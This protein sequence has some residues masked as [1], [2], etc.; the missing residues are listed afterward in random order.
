[1]SSS[2]KEQGTAAFHAEKWEEAIN[3]YTEALKAGSLSEEEA[4]ALYSNRAAARIHLYRYDLALLD[5]AQACKLRPTWSRAFAR[6]AEAYSHLHRDDLALL[7][8]QE[9]ISLAEDPS[10]R[11]RYESAA[12]LVRQRIET[13]ANKT[14]ALISEV[15][16]NDFC[17]RYNELL[18]KEDPRVGSGEL[19]SAEAAVYAYEMIEKAMLELDDQ[20]LM[21]EDGTVEA[22]SPSPILDIADGIL[23]D[24]R[25]FHIPPGKDEKCPLAQKLT[26]QLECDLRVLNLNDYIKR[27]ATPDELLDDFH[28]MVQKEDNWELARLSLSTLIRGSFVSG[29]LAEAQGDTYLA[30][31]KYLYALGIVEAGRERWVDVSDDDRGSSF[32]F[33]FARNLKVH[34]MLALETALWKASTLE[35]R[36]TVS[37]AQIQNYAEEIMEHCVTNRLPDEPIM[38]L[39]FQIHPIVNAG[40]AIG[41]CLGQRSRDAENAV[42]DGPA[43]YHHPSLAAA[44]SKMYTSAGAMLPID[45]PDRPLNLYHSISYSLRAGGISVGAVFTRVAEAEAAMTPPEAVFGPTTRHFDSRT[46]VRSVADDV[47][48]WIEH[49]SSTSED[50]LQAVE[51][52]L[53]VELQ[54]V[55]TVKEA[56]VEEGK[57]WVEMVDEGFRKE[58][59]GSLALCESI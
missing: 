33:T 31:S 16:T 26:I 52:A 19:K 50:P 41:F 54:P 20:M 34:I 53:L 39:A 25:G 49:L 17:A 36:E 11:Q 15:E 7:T 43:L 24:P 46:F 14:S 9:A 35:E 55:P 12:S 6:R 56:E 59:P 51:D 32:R 42:K 38:H 5:A 23:T 58:L 18:K 3:L 45:D 21:S 48:G 37:L 30:L 1:M 27:N 44:A 40:K 4:G 22:V 13:L 47:R 2:L 29:F 8:Y 57:R 28:A 10:T